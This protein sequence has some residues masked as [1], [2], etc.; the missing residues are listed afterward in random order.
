[1]ADK[2]VKI[3]AT[4]PLSYRD[5]IS[6]TKEQREAGSIERNVVE[7]S[8]A[9]QKAIVGV[10]QQVALQKIA[11]NQAEV[12]LAQAETTAANNNRVVKQS[13]PFSASAIIKELAAG[14]AAVARAT[15]ALEAATNTLEDYEEQLALLKEVQAE[16]FPG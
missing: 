9:M 2:K 16:L 8:F 1:M 4:A 12:D 7:G 15:S 3:A 11:V 14:K 5:L 10:E 6:Q 13:V